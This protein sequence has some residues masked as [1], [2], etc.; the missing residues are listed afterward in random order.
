VELEGLIAVGAVSA[1]AVLCGVGCGRFDR[2]GPKEKATE[3]RQAASSR[4]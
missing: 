4:G 1:R 3:L 2:G